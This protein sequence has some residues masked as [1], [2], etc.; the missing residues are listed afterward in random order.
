MLTLI[1]ASVKLKYIS[2]FYSW[3]KIYNRCS[4]YL[5]KFLAKIE[6][7]SEIGKMNAHNLAIVI[8]PNVIWSIDDER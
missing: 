3:L 8:A 4:R 2:P 1:K 5:I 6:Q 7:N